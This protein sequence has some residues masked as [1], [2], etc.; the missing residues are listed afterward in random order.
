MPLLPKEVDLAPS[1]LFSLEDRPWTVAHVRSRQEK[2]LSRHLLRHAVPFY[3]PL[4]ERSL[5]IAGRIRSAFHPLF[6]G[7]VFA[8]PS[9]AE[10]AL[11]LRSNAVVSLI[12]VLDQQQL[13][14][15]LQQIRALQDAGATF[16]PKVAFEP[17]DPVR[18]TEG[19]FTGYRG[20]V[21]RASGGERL[22]IRISLIQQAVAVE[23]D[24]ELLRRAR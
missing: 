6:P 13:A 11:V 16:T 10:R 2:V 23:F 12:D 14:E 18:V 24:R 22:V 3:A 7:Y 9:A 21:V 17:G 1:D 4:I 20:V 19:V 15:E 8:R 5:V